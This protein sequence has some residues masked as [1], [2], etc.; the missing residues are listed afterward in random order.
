M[1]FFFSSVNF[2]FRPS[3]SI[4]KCFCDVYVF[5]IFRKGSKNKLRGKSKKKTIK[6]ETKIEHG[7]SCW[8]AQPFHSL[9]PELDQIT[10]HIFSLSLSLSLSIASDPENRY[11]VGRRENW[12][13]RLSKPHKTLA[14]GSS[15]R[16]EVFGC[17]FF[18]PFFVVV[19]HKFVLCFLL[20]LLMCAEVNGLDNGERE[21]KAG[22]RENVKMLDIV[23]SLQAMQAITKWENIFIVP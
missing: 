22:G 14:R 4:K 12:I 11:R 2:S 23:H 13:F 1:F 6:K 21:K 5:S 3:I 19:E 18:L 16:A 15:G 9:K 7:K 20:Q 8:V 17:L 10:H